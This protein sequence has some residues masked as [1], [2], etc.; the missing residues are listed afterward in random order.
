MPVERNAR[1][2]TGLTLFA[3]AACHFASH[4]TGLFR[5]QTMDAVGRNVLLAPWQTL[6]GRMALLAAVLIHGGLG[7]RALYRRRHMRIPR[8][9]AMQ[10]GLGLLIPFLLLPHVVNV[11]LGA[12]LYGLD[13]S[14]YR[15]LYQ[16]W[17]TPPATGLVRQ[18]TLLLAVWVHGCIGLHFWLRRHRWYG[19]WRPALLAV[20]ALLPFLAVLGL[21]NAG[22]DTAMT[23]A[24]H[25]DFVAA[26]GPPPPGTPRA[27]MLASLRALWTHLQYGYVA[28]VAAVLALRFVR[29]QHAR[30][31]AVRITYPD[32]QVIAAPKGFSVLEASRWARI[33]HASVCGGRG[34]CS[35]CRIHV[36]RGLSGLPPPAPGERETL[37]RV[38]AP[39]GVRLACQLRPGHDLWVAPLLPVRV[40]A[41]SH[42]IPVG[43]S[44]ELEVTALFVDLRES[45]RLAAGRLPFDMLFIIES[46]IRRV[47]EAVQAHG[48]EITSIAGDGIMSVFGVESGNAAEGA[49]SGLRAAL[50]IWESLDQLSEELAAEIG[51][52]LSF[53]IG[54][55]SGLSA[56]GSI[57][58]MG[59]PSTR[60]LG[61]TGNVAARL[62]AITKDLGCPLVV[63]VATLARA[64][65]EIPSQVRSFEIR[66][67]GRETEICHIVPLRNRDAARSLLPPPALPAA[68]GRRRQLLQGIKRPAVPA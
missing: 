61:D 52:P 13:D 26:H 34:R 39:S 40:N 2:V 68:T 30:W 66:L 21:V 48:G 1:L 17:L 49:V 32:G 65:R 41:P 47:T 62:E 16:Y 7:L 36:L 22:W 37:A 42:R 60:F 44:Q 27:R 50:A 20:A 14:Y 35:T 59:R 23:A 55:H 3:Y 12:S 4:A 63:S 46:Y 9:E 57:L 51:K 54:L 53:G 25:P 11:R 43:E 67:R 58:V 38:N 15:I 10:L 31:A 28:L 45:T 33:P 64:E 8:A 29:S 18:F 56:V 19:R 6:A 24:F 5:L